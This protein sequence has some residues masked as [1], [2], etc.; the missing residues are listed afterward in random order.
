VRNVLDSW[1]AT[2]ESPL[3]NGFPSSAN[4]E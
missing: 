3:D 4:R 1:T 2:Q